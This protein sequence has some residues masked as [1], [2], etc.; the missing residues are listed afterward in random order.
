MIFSS[1]FYI[2]KEYFFFRADNSYRQEIFYSRIITPSIVL[3]TVT[4]YAKY[5]PLPPPQ[6][7]PA[8]A[9]Q[10]PLPIPIPVP[11]PFQ[12]TTSFIPYR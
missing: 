9:S 5:S 2:C 7:L 3:H 12:R 4:I 1:F 8:S 6:H 10:F 11:P